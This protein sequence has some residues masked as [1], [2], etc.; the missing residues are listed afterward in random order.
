MTPETIQSLR[1]LAEAAT[2]GKRKWMMTRRGAAASE[3]YAE[4]TGAE[5]LRAFD[6]TIEFEQRDADLIAA[7]NPATILQL[8]DEIELANR[9]LEKAR[10]ALAGLMEAHRV[11]FRSSLFPAFQ[12][13]K[14]NFNGAWVKAEAALAELEGK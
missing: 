1:R 13:G 10:S 9:K 5:I 11:V 8:L 6:Y 14:T 7:C 3:L 12:A 4:D 2:P